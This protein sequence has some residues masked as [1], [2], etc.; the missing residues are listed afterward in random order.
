[1]TGTK[2]TTSSGI[3]YLYL[4]LQ[5]NCSADSNA[6]LANFCTNDAIQIGDSIIIE[7]KVS[8]STTGITNLGASTANTTAATI[9]NK[10]NALPKATETSI[11]DALVKDGNTCTIVKLTGVTYTAKGF[12]DGIDTIAYVNKLY[13]GTLKLDNGRKY[14]ITGIK[15]YNKIGQI[16]PRSN[17]DIYLYSNDTTLATFTVNG[18]T[19]IGKDSLKF[20]NFADCKGIAIAT[21]DTNATFS[22]RV[23]LTNV[24]ADDLAN[25]ELAE[26]DSVIVTT[27]AEDGTIGKYKVVIA[28]DPDYQEITVKPL[29]K[30][31]YYWGDTVNIHWSTFRVENATNQDSIIIYKGNEQIF[32]YHIDIT[33]KQANIVLGDGSANCLYDCYGADYS[34]SVKN[35][36]TISDTT[37]LFTLIPQT[38]IKNILT[39][40][41]KFKNTVRIKGLV[42][43][44]NWTSKDKKYL[45]LTMQDNDADSSAI[46]VNYCT[47]KDVE[48]GDSVSIEGKISN[49]TATNLTNLGSSTNKT[50]A[51]IINSNN[52]IPNATETT[53]AD[54]L[55][56]DGKTCTLIKL[57]GVKFADNYFTDGKDTIAYESKLYSGSTLL[58][59]SRTYDITGIKGYNKIGQIWPRSNDDIYLYNNDT[60]LSTFTVNGQTAIGKDSLKF[61]NFADCKGIAI[62]TAD[63]NATFSVRVN[64]TN[65]D[66]DDLAN[67]ELAE[68]DSVI[69]T[70]V[71]EDGTV[72]KY[73]V[74]IAKDNTHLK[75]NTLAT[76]EFGTGDTVSL[77]W[78]QLNIAEINIVLSLGGNNILLNSN[79]MQAN[80][81]KHQYVVPNSMF[82]QGVV[83][84]IRV[85][86]NATLD[87]LY[88]SITDTKS[89]T[90]TF[91]SPANG[92]SQVAVNTYLTLHFDDA[93]K[94]SENAIINIG[95]IKAELITLSDTSAKAFANGLKYGETYKITI[96]AGAITDEAGNNAIIGDWTFTTKAAPK[97]DLYFSEYCEGAIG[98]NKYYEIYNPK[99][100][101]VDLSNYIVMASTNGGEWKNRLQLSGT[102]SSESVFI[103]MNS[104]ADTLT[105][106]ADI[107]TT[108]TLTFN[109][110]DALGLFKISGNDTM[111]ID[112]IGNYGEDPGTAW[113]VAGIKNATKDHVLVRKEIAGGTSNWTESAGT[114]SLD[115]QWIVLEDADYSNIGK[116]G[117]GHRTDI[118]TFEF[119][120]IK[121]DATINSDSA[122]IT[123]ETLYGTDLTK[124]TPVFT[125]SRGAQLLINNKQVS[126]TTIDFSKPVKATVV[127]EDCLN[128]KDWTITV[129]T[130]AK[131][132]D[133][134]EILFFKF[135]EASAISTCI[136]S[137]EALIDILMP[138]GTNITEL[139][140]WFLISPNASV[141]STT[142]KLAN[143]QV[144]ST[145]TMDF[146]EPQTI[147]IYAEDKTMK[148]WTIN[149]EIDQPLALTIHNIQFT[150][151]DSSSYVNK[152]VTTE[153]IITSTYT[154]GKGTE[155]YIQDSIGEW[156]GILVYDERSKLTSKAK[157]G[158]KVSVTGVV[159][160]YFTITEIANLK[161]FKIISENNPVEPMVLTAEDAKT[162]KFESVLVT[163]NGLTCTNENGDT[164]A[165]E[166]ETDSL[167]VYNKYKI[168]EFKMYKDSIYNATGIMYYHSSS[169]TYEIIP[170]SLADIVNVTPIEPI[171]TIPI[172]VN[173]TI[174]AIN[175]YAFNNTIV[176][177][178]ADADIYVFDIA[179]K[180]VAIRKN[181]SNRVEIKM[182]NSGL[183]IIRVGKEAQK[184]IIK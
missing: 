115:S 168:S 120:G 22:V 147:D 128:T 30:D 38:S 26:N 111:L 18:Q 59:G 119:A 93:V 50:E 23:N 177:E 127:A 87:S 97:E 126:S 8:N 80:S 77:T 12:T 98:N 100:T 52:A 34:L 90:A 103:A 162:E 45:Y 180:A 175:I 1:M 27:V 131:L 61:W 35:D 101:A 73:K 21:A 2:S 178:N 72:G 85:K 88:I 24:D 81:G 37:D 166:D 160:E 29:F 141:S 164:F 156:S 56:K 106:L 48:T 67:L 25:L 82:G 57:V 39:N 113:N 104:K 62:A 169:K 144:S 117:I 55:K 138:Y 150:K 108:S 136:M 19:A 75:F 32:R 74:V 10:G 153:G 54:A 163:I 41:N 68:N 167:S 76:S 11:A 161:N 79:P 7:G 102:L 154:N 42:T 170:R 63:T 70:T 114:D 14:D 44:T 124:L 123:I 181:T 5:D 36:K 173:E 65:V 47:N 176:V 6:I 94:I 184:V 46:L 86:D 89:P 60:T 83:K 91:L 66:A 4:T 135:I 182:P 33:E 148:T 28:N 71:A 137:D 152:L 15:G 58:N 112:I 125:L 139:T 96:P 40:P 146:S 159:T 3:E 116:H 9:I 107:L 49:S 179:G 142:L 99:A 155:L 78:T 134:A 20:W 143:F 109:G 84:A 64:L 172:A 133:E 145:V 110:D 171:D 140:P 130:T 105:N 121:S 174:S 95:D 165:V 158:D 53:I 16:W 118:L 183:Y 17:E 43:G 151:N 129:T 149:V 157:V 51:T 31:K 13:S 132:S 69:V 122:T 92:A